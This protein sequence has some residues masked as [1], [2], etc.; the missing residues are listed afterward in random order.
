MEKFSIPKNKLNDI[1]GFVYQ[2]KRE[3]VFK[4]KIF[5]KD[6]NNTGVV[7]NSLGKVDI[8]HRLEPTLKQ[9]PHNIEN[10][11]EYDPEELDEILRP[12]LC[13][14]LECI[15]RFYNEA[16]NPNYWYLDA[17]RALTNNIA[18]I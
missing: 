3:R 13:V 16:N 8:L 11:P 9:N 6:K 2:T 5:G 15:M 4:V 7:C 14:L 17:I 1:I 10:W 12:G 18:K